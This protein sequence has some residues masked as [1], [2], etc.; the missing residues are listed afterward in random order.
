MSQ[1]DR[2]FARRHI[3]WKLTEITRESLKKDSCYTQYF[4]ILLGGI[5]TEW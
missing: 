4:S 5:K 3:T 2:A 1:Y